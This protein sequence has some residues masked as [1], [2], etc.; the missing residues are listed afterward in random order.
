ML[1]KPY[2]GADK[3]VGYGSSGGIKFS[4]Y[5]L[6][7]EILQEFVQVFDCLVS[8]APTALDRPLAAMLVVLRAMRPTKP[9]LL[10][11]L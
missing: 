3:L 6:V 7:R 8:S 5:Y 1:E 4:R 9:V 11:C 10:C 2:P